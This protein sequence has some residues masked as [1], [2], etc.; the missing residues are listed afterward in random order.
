VTGTYFVSV[1]LIET[2]DGGGHTVHCSKV[3]GAGLEDAGMIVNN[4]TVDRLKSERI[5]TK[6]RSFADDIPL[7]QRNHTAVNQHSEV[8]NE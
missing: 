1:M 5:L 3:P 6:L 7:S 8:K 4:R 2:V